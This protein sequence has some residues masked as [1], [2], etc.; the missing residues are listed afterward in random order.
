[1]SGFDRRSILKGIAA[2]PAMA[3]A[4]QSA[5]INLLGNGAAMGLAGGGMAVPGYLTG[6]T[7]PEKFFKF[8][9]WF[10]GVGRSQAV[11]Q[12]R[13]VSELDPDLIGMRLPLASKVNMQRS[14]NY[15]RIVEDQRSNFERRLSL[16]G[17]FE[18]WP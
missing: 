6:G 4:V 17:F 18:W 15:A 12:A 7:K 11:N 9:D 14:R 5:E 13:H 2:S 8:A 3:M 1:M 16:N 10:K